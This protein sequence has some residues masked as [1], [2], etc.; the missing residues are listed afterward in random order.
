MI[1]MVFDSGRQIWPQPDF[2]NPNI[3]PSNPQ[4]V[5][6]IPTPEEWAAFLE[7]VE[8]ARKFDEMTG[9]PDCEDPDKAL[10][11]EAIEGRLKALEE[12]RAS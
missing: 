4:P 7:L 12:W 9:Q 3:F 11:F 5:E 10:W 2:P 1:S 6:R 8:K